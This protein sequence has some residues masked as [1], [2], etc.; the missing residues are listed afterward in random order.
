MARGHKGR[1]R[2]YAP[3]FNTPFAVIGCLYR[4]LPLRTQI[5]VPRSFTVIFIFSVWFQI[6]KQYN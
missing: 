4:V 3:C 1:R 5:D 2:D 6:Q